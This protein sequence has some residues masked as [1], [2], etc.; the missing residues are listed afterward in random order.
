MIAQ[1]M[2]LKSSVSTAK[3]NNQRNFRGLK[4]KK[5]PKKPTK[6]KG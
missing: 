4:I 5:A 6:T 1:I 2:L 3:L